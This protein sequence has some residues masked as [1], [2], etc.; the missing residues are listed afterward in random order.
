MKK[1]V[2]FLF[3]FPIRT[4]PMLITMP[5]GMNVITLLDRMGYEIDIYLSEYRNDSYE[6]LFS[7]NVKIHFLDHNYLWPKEGI[8]SYLS[9]TSYFRYLSAIKLRNE[10][11]HI[12]ASGMAGITLGGILKRSNRNSKFI[13][14]NDEFPV[15]GKTNIW[16]ISEIKHARKADLVVTPDEMRFPPLAAQIKG[17]DKIDHCVLPNAPLLEE[18][19]NI[20]EIN[21]H[22]RFVID[23]SKKLFLVAGGIQPFNFIDELLN[24]VPL[25]PEDCVLILKGKSTNNDFRA[26]HLHLEKEKKI[27]WNPEQLSPNELHSLI[28]YCVASLCLYH[29]INDNLRF[30]GKSSGKLMRSVLLGKPVI[31][32]TQSAFEFVEELGLGILV[33]DEKTLAEAVRNMAQ[34]HKSHEINCWKHRDSLSFESYWETF[35]QKA[36]L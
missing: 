33:S 13:Y 36:S 24:S 26:R 29:P 4:N 12:I 2:A 31:A 16:V 34:N 11:S 28:Q 15:Q 22:K 32:T 3:A 10:Y 30:V 7:E 18:L 6:G 8:Q 1:K 25:W 35:V 27:V 23:P 20:P 9:L 14:L 17:L 5:F 19:E 21:W